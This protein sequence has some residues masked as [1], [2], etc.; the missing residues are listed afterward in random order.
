MV[1]DGLSL[2]DESS[3]Q[4]LGQVT[5]MVVVGCQLTDE[6]VRHITAMPS[7]ST[8]TLS[9]CSGVSVSSWSALC[10][11]DRL[12]QLYVQKMWD[13]ATLQAVAQS[14]HPGAF[15]ALVLDQCDVTDAGLAALKNCRLA[16][17]KVYLQDQDSELQ[18]RMQ[19]A[20][21]H[22]QVMLSN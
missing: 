10:D 21:P 1:L 3:L 7:L 9:A 13:D 17:V 14:H 2:T 16:Q 6:T 15:R 11:S 12:N 18:Q 20:L 8:L 19:A 22:A 4:S 5:E